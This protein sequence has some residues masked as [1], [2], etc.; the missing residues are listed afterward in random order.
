MKKQQG[1]PRG[2]AWPEKEP[3]SNMESFKREIAFAKL[4]QWADDVFGRTVR[5]WPAANDSQRNEKIFRMLHSVRRG[6]K[7]CGSGN[8]VKYLMHLGKPLMRG[9]DHELFD[10]RKLFEHYSKKGNYLVGEVIWVLGSDA[11]FYSHVAK[12]GRIHHSSFFGGGA[13]LAGGDWTVK[14]GILSEITGVSGHYKPDKS[15][16]IEALMV[17]VSKSVIAEND[18]VVKVWELYPK[19]PDGILVSYMSLLWNNDSLWNN[20]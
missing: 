19:N 1:V 5:N 6:V 18:K 8:R 4:I 20:C 16:L 3:I 9:P 2:L 11:H 17:L 12:R 10:T 15:R 7:Y 14:D 13:I